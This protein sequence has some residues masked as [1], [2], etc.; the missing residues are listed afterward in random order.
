MTPIQEQRCH[1][2]ELREDLGGLEPGPLGPSIVEERPDDADDALRLVQDDVQVAPRGLIRGN[3]PAQDL[4]TAGND[5]ERRPYLVGNLGRQH[6]HG[7]H[8]LG[9]LHLLL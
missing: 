7:G 6:A 3:G 9:L 8:L 5:V 2:S 4:G 1:P